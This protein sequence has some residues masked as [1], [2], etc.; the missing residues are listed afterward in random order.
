MARHAFFISSVV[1]GF[2][3][4][5]GLAETVRAQA[6][7]AAISI[8]PIAI[9]TAISLPMHRPIRSNW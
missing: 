2:I 8:R 3:S 6:A 1:A 9:A 4:M 5:A 7:R